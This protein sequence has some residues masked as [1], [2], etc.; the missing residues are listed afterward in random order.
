MV[1]AFRV[2]VIKVAAALWRTYAPSN[3]YGQLSNLHKTAITDLQWSSVY[4]MIYTVS[5]D[6]TIVMS[7]L[8]TGERI[9]RLR[10]HSGIINAISST[11]AGG[12][13]VELLATA[14]DDGTVKVWEGGD[15]GSKHCVADWQLGCPVTAVCWGPD[16]NQVYI[17]ALDNLIHVSSLEN[18][19]SHHSNSS[20]QVYD[21]RKGEEVTILG[22]HTDTPTSISLS[23]DGGFLPPSTFSTNTQ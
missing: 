11:T 22:G 14:A 4:P 21:L 2:E 23:P 8:T 15:E 12:S 10:G 18:D 6:K 5:A 9:K 17:G 19:Q 16:G 13:G 1:V 7:D 3:N 20:L